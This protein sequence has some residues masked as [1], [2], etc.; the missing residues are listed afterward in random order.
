MKSD[1]ACC[2]EDW[3]FLAGLAMML[4]GLIGLLVTWITKGCFRCS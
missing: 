3:G 4:T 1:V 2:P